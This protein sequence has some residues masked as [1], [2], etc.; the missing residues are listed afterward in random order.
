M[1]LLLMLLVKSL[2]VF[3]LSGAA[4]LCLRRAA[5]SAR[6]LAC[7]LTLSAL[8]ALPLFSLT[9]PGW[10]LAGLQTR[11]AKSAPVY[12]EP[13]PVRP[14]PALPMKKGKELRQEALL[15]PAA[16]PS[17][18]SFIG[19]TPAKSL[20]TKQGGRFLLAFYLL[21]LLFASLRP[22]LGLWGIAHLRR[23]C[24]AVTEAP[25]LSLSADCAAALG[26]PCLPRLCRADVPVPMTWGWLQPVVLLPL[27]SAS[28]PEDRLRSV[29][30]HEMAHVK[31]R[32]WP[33][34][35]LADAACAL[36]WFHPLVW[37][38]A[39]R[40]RA[41]SEAACD[42]LVLASGIPAP[43]YARHL[44]D[45]ARAL[46]PASRPPQSAAI[47]MA[48]TSRLKR[49]ITMILDKTQ[50]RRAV[51]RRALLVA[52]V[53]SAAALLMLSALRPSVKAQAAPVPLAA[54][55]AAAPQFAKL[56]VTNMEIDGKPLL[57]G[58]T[59]A[60]KPGSPWWSAAGALLPTPVYN[61][62][63]YHAESHTSPDK[64]TVSLAFRLPADATG[65]TVRYEL[66]QSVQFSSDGT[67]VGKMQNDVGL[68]ETQQFTH[69]GGTRVV[70]A[71]YPAGTSKASIRIGIASG[72]WNLVTEIVPG[73]TDTAA[74]TTPAG[75]FIVGPLESASS[76][77][78]LSVSASQLT[79]DI[80]IVGLDMAGRDELPTTL[81]DQSIETL[82][83]ITAHF[84]FPLVPLKAVRVET[85]PFQWIE[86]KDVALQPVK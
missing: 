3:A 29:L 68:T 20:L 70:T 81:G 85:R 57:A 64:H 17:A 43:D 19:R 39:R 26:L 24:A 86:F 52:L 54:S 80:R 18:S 67:W 38:T 77:D 40:L 49:R 74:T 83:Q 47:A 78:I 25:I 11:D 23:A 46:P 72:P 50:S 48:Q 59:D 16:S 28:W 10:H 37:L 71:E 58:I 21:G 9:L 56:S 42:D 69:T 27:G 14:S 84:N 30:L 66:P 45:I 62:N 79:Q 35:R 6:H 2:L 15:V 1:T 31:R 61:T 32:D 82:D 75:S 12:Q 60:A 5:A 73:Q 36:Y 44:L 22:L 34:H 63:A 53:P 7:L 33:G 13:A 8:L 4:L 55:F 76:G 65:D 41:E 51:P